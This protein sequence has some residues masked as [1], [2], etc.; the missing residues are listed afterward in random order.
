MTISLKPI[1]IYQELEPYD[2]DVDNRP[3]LDIQDNL[4][5]ITTLLEASGYYS[6]IGADPS[7][8]PANGF[9]TFTCASVYSNSLLIPIDISKAVSEID[10]TKYPI[11]LI[12]G[13]KSDIKKYACLYFSAGIKLS[14]K[15]ASFVPG[16][17]GRLIRVG[18]GG[19]LV[20]QLY[21]D[22]AHASKGYQALY[23]GKILNPNSIVFGGNQVN[24]LG[25]NYYLAKNRDDSTSGLITVQRSN[26][27]S[28]IIF[29]A[30]NYNEVGSPYNFAEYVNT[31][32][33]IGSVSE[34]PIPVYFSSTQLSYNQATGLFTEPL[35]ETYLNEVHFNTPPLTSISSSNKAYLTA[36]V[37]VRSLLEFNLTNVIH[38]AAYSNNISELNQNISTKLTFTDREKVIFTDPDIPI[39]IG[40]NSKIKSIGDSIEKLTN[41][42]AAILPVIDTTGITFGDYYG[43]GGAYF[44]SVEDDL[45]KAPG[46]PSETDDLATQNVSGVITSN[47][48]TEYSNS[49]NLLLSAKS[50]TTIPS[51]IIVSA[52]GYINLSSGKGVLLNNAIPKLGLEATSKVY[53]DTLFG[54]VSSSDSNKIPLTGTATDKNVTGNIFIDVAGNTGS[55]TKVLTLQGIN[56]VDVAS[57]NKIRFIDATGTNTSGL[58]TLLGNTTTYNPLTGIADGDF[59][60][61][62]KEFVKA[63]VTDSVIGGSG[64][65][66]TLGT[67]QI[68][69]SGAKTFTNTITSSVSVGTIG[70]SLRTDELTALA[71]D[72]IVD[73]AGSLTIGNALKPVLGAKETQASDPRETLTTKGYIDD[74]IADVTYASAPFYAIWNH[75][76]DAGINVPAGSLNYA[77]RHA[78]GGTA[79]GADIYLNFDT[80]FEVNAANGLVYK[81]SNT[82]PILLQVNA[83]SSWYQNLGADQYRVSCHILVNA[84]SVASAYSQF[85]GPAGFAA[86]PGAAVSAVVK[87]NPGDKLVVGAKINGDL[88]FGLPINHYLSMAKIG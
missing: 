38:G 12:L 68:N 63:Y 10:Y 88:T 16:S 2:V 18:P 6:E 77:C 20:D 71:A 50:T 25:N 36:G 46:R 31:S 67:T 34:S 80:F 43:L 27:S 39:G 29:K 9:S 26:T 37:N 66:V 87:L 33:N 19:Q 81:A 24:I 48:I 14:S 57:Y 30:I 17:E 44:G 86:R 21:Y 53:V 64:V 70:I 79:A 62:N 5:E 84:T 75:V 32:S 15:F 78:A 65:Y 85:D 76:E 83:G 52:D 3:L 56:W 35:L 61:V 69:I 13:Y 4:T 40:M 23:V 72:L 45:T 58:Q 51:N 74:A 82:A 59:E 7:Q 60:L 47:I 42:P 28:N 11:V 54:Q 22:L 1:S 49:F 55:N 73:T 41:L 8:E